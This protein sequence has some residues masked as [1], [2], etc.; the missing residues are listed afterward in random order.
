[1]APHGPI[2]S[3]WVEVGWIVVTSIWH[4]PIRIATVF[5]ITILWLLVLCW[6]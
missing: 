1:M 5:G 6:W 4:M 3:D 2:S